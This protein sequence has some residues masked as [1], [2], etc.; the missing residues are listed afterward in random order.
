MQNRILTDFLR[1][2]DRIKSA[3]FRVKTI[4]KT[5]KPEIDLIS[6]LN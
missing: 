1:I 3:D 4:Q 6:F 5:V 2:N